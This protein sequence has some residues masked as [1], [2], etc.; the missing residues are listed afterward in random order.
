MGGRG[1]LMGIQLNDNEKAAVKTI[2]DKY[3]DEYEQFR[4][5]NR[6]TAQRGQRGQNA[7]LATQLLA[8]QER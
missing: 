2:S 6:G 1:A 8:I 7:Q 3:R 4:E 5:A